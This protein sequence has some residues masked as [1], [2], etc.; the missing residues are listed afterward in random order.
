ML[1]MQQESI[2][3]GKGETTAL[4]NSP[5]ESFPVKAVRKLSTKEIV[6]DFSLVPTT[7]LDLMGL[8]G[9]Q[10]LEGIEIP[11]STKSAKKGWRLTAKW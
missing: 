5:V 6:G 9:N 11:S 10:Q 7:A 1:C 8:I 2:I 4:K 3:L